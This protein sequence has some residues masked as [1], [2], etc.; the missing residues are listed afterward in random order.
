M[1]QWHCPKNCHLSSICSH[2]SSVAVSNGCSLGVKN[3]CRQPCGSGSGTIQCMFT[4]PPIPTLVLSNCARS[5]YRLCHV[6]QPAPSAVV[7]V[8]VVV[9]VVILVM[10]IMV[11]MIVIAIIIE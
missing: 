11:L 10:L 9:K 8:V 4:V 2:E 1:F 7:V 5:M 3:A 6:H